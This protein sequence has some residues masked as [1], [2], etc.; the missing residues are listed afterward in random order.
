MAYLQEVQSIA[1]LLLVETNLT[2]APRT[3]ARSRQIEAEE[4]VNVRRPPTRSADSFTDDPEDQVA[5]ATIL[6]DDQIDFL[7]R[8]GD[9]LYR[10]D[11]TDNDDVFRYGDG[12]VE[13]G[14]IGLDKQP[15]Q[16]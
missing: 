12:D 7:D 8:D 15:S 4:R 6:E 2:D 3:M 5:A 10:D 11:F 1:V 16:R 14:A 13:E 9:D